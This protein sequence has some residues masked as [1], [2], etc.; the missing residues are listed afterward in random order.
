MTSGSTP[1]TLL[2]HT[3]SAEHLR[4]LLS[5]RGSAGVTD[6]F[7]TSEGSRRKLELYAVLLQANREP[8]SLGP[9]PAV[10]VAWN[11][12][13]EAE[14][15]APDAVRPILLH[16]QVGSW[17]AYSLRR[18]LGKVTSASPSW[19]DVGGLHILALAASAAAGLSWRTAVP[20]RAGRVMLPALGMARFDGVTDDV[21][22]VAETSG[23]R[24]R[25]QLGDQ[26]VTVPDDPALDGPGWWGLRRVRVA[27]EPALSVWLDDLDPFRD[28]AD[29]EPPTRL[30]DPSFARW[31]QLLTDAWHLLLRDHRAEA[32]AMAGGF[33]S[34]VPL[35]HEEG[36]GTR[37]ASSGEAFGSIMTSLPP[38]A[39]TLAE[40]LVHEYQHITL[41]GLIHHLTFS[42]SDDRLYYAPWRFDPR[43][44]GG[45]LQGVFAF[46]GIASFWR[47]HRLTAPEPEREAASYEYAHARAQT[48][49]ALR[50]LR[51]APGLTDDGRALTEGISERCT[52]WLDEEVSA[53]AGRL[54][55]L[56]TD[57][58]RLGWQL[59]HERPSDND[60]VSHLA[61]AWLADGAPSGFPAPQE[62]HPDP[63]FF[64]QDLIP[65][66]AKRR[67]AGRDLDP[68]DSTG[69]ARIVAQA[70]IDLVHGEAKVAR[71]GFHTAITA[72][73]DPGSP[74]EIHAW[75]GLA[76]ALRATEQ[77]PAAQ[78]L[79]DRPDL[80]RAVYSRLVGLGHAPDPAE[81]AGWIGRWLEAA[82]SQR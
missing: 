37:S 11:A 36:W 76:M 50:I 4:L 5:G 3:L 25:L 27:G 71:D 18:A 17:A 67:L 63:E 61:E 59:R 34:L 38:D 75:A 52:P 21:V 51:D 6:F 41:G 29:P 47:Q 64:W 19:V 45:F 28:L 2:H 73:F 30:D 60:Q 49:A 57:S 48:H 14:R 7:W 77:E 54:A 65:T 74:A 43:P 39:V 53:E 82:P 22:V 1:I 20:A 58:H 72:G 79:Y 46:L 8:A 10:D 80:V 24:I 44:L 55:G 78:T 23:G 26:T 9:L 32:E 33:V 12:L 42:A 68:G 70:Q 35:R 13:A 40:V 81:L 62:L 15:A 31:A 69:M 66:F 56:A 16:P